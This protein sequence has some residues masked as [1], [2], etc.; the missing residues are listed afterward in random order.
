[1]A[2]VADQWPA[3]AGAVPEVTSTGVARGYSIQQGGAS[4]DTILAD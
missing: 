4:A 2:A 1:M 3:S